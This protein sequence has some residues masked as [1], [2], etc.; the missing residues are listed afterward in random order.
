MPVCFPSS[1]SAENHTAPC[2][3]CDCSKGPIVFLA[4]SVC[5]REPCRAGVEGI[6]PGT[7]KFKKKI[8][9]RGSRGVAFS[10]C[11]VCLGRLGLGQSC[12]AAVKGWGPWSLPEAR[13]DAVPLS[14]SFGGLNLGG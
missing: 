2:L 9:V 10:C 3:T 6:A 4:S 7:S 8:L 5:W 1:N 13:L 14:P 11:L 12:R